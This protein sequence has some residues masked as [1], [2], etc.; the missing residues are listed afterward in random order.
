MANTKQSSGAKYRR[1]SFF[2]LPKIFWQGR[3]LRPHEKWS[4]EKILEYQEKGLRKLRD[5]AYSNSP[6]YKKFHQGHENSPLNELP[7]LTK[8]QLMQSWDEIV[9][10]R[11]LHLK[12]EEN[13]L[14]NLKGLGLFQGKYFAWATGG[15][16]GVK[17]IF[18]LSQKEW[19]KFFFTAVRSGAAQNISLHFGQKPRMALDWHSLVL[20]ITN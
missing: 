14:D 9:T 4:K 20:N 7:I 1:L 15:T 16:T 11:S 5:F 3:K 13:F 17:G 2:Q 8:K 10:D 19:F 6:F 18:I 12:D